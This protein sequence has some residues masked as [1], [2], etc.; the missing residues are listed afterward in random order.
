MWVFVR[1][2]Y[3]ALSLQ[4]SELPSS[5]QLLPLLDILRPSL[6]AASAADTCCGS[7]SALLLKPLSFL[8]ARPG[9]NN[10]AVLWNLDR[11]FRIRRCVMTPRHLHLSTLLWIGMTAF[12]QRYIELLARIHHSS[13][14]R[15]CLDQHRGATETLIS[16]YWSEVEDAVIVKSNHSIPSVGFGGYNN[17]V[18]WPWLNMGSQI[19]RDWW[20]S[21]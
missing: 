5:Q 1:N 20:R 15:W 7:G 12:A 16:T 21:K 14:P 2:R 6:L 9:T 4:K 17:V 13:P 10:G 18:T 11:S 8:L 3:I 19:W